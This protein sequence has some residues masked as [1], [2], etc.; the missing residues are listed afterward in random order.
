MTRGQ[1]LEGGRRNAQHSTLNTQHSTLNAQRSTPNTQRSTLNVQ[2][3]TSNAQRRDQKS[4][5]GPGR[6]SAGASSERR[7]SIPNLNGL[8]ESRLQIIRGAEGPGVG[9]DET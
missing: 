8:T 9:A 7:Y 2:R 6:R 3:P 5:R 1:R 4:R